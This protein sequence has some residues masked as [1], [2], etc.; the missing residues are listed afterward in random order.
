MSNTD[1]DW[2][3]ESVIGFLNSPMWNLPVKNFMESNCYGKMNK[4]L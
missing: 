3:F 4:T 2:L 1:D